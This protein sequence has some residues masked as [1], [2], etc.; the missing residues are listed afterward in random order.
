MCARVGRPIEMISVPSSSGNLLIAPSGLERK[1]G[2]GANFSP[3]LIGE[4]SDRSDI[5]RKDAADHLISVPSSSG[6]LLIARAERARAKLEYDFSPLLIGES[7]DRRCYCPQ[8]LR[9]RCPIS[10]PS[11]SG[12]LLIGAR[13]RLRGAARLIS[14]P[15][16]SGNLLIGGR[17]ERKGWSQS[18]ISVPSSS[19]NLLIATDV[20]PALSAGST[21]FSPLLIGESSVRAATAMDSY[22]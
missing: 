6:N 9:N 17:C 13:R 14:V 7:S 19:G 11:S 15:S 4:S 5:G 1:G 3:L 16:S 18:S 12:N 22:S 10:V 2:R 21:N 8:R 20:C